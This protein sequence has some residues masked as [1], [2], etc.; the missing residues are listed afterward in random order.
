MMAVWHLNK[1]RLEEISESSF[2]KI[3]HFTLNGMEYDVVACHPCGCRSRYGMLLPS[4]EKRTFPSR[5]YGNTYVGIFKKQTGYS[6]EAMGHNGSHHNFQVSLGRIKPGSSY[7][8]PTR[9]ETFGSPPVSNKNRIL[10]IGSNLEYRDGRVGRTDTPQGSDRE[11]DQKLTQITVEMAMQN[12]DISG[13]SIDSQHDDLPVLLA[14]GFT[15][16]WRDEAIAT[17]IN[18]FRSAP[19]N[20]LFPPYRDYRIASACFGLE[21][22]DHKLVYYA[23]QSLKN[24]NEGLDSEE[25]TSASSS[26][27]SFDPD[28]PHLKFESWQE[29]I[30]RAPILNPGAAVLPEY[31]EK[32][33]N[34]V[35]EAEGSESSSSC[36]SS[37]DA[38]TIRE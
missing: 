2:A 25:N 27:S 16:P 31:W 10:Y 22:Y 32:K 26:S 13:V 23:K 3:G 37:T 24:A 18:T 33:P 8:D 29:I 14:G 9:E 5:T 19:E 20:K 36:D 4:E 7:Y 30:E 17:E 6:L 34:I 11:L 35:D 28:L 38:Q 1:F 15:S 21:N 12:K